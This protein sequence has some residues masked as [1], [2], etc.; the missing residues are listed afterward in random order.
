[1]HPEC[2][3][4]HVPHSGQFPVQWEKGIPCVKQ[5]HTKILLASQNKNWSIISLLTNVCSH[6]G[7]FL[8]AEML[9]PILARTESVTLLFQEYFILQ[10]MRATRL[11]VTTKI[12]KIKCNL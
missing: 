10:Y 5:C 4:F 6:T 7:W 3:E 2:H 1:M 9:S 12:T 11:I 8:S